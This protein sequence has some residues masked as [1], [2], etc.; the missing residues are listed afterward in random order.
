MSQGKTG[1]AALGLGVFDPFK[2]DKISIDQKEGPVVLKIDLKDAN[3]RGLSG[4]SL[5]QK[6]SFFVLFIKLYLF[7]SDFKFSKVDGF[8]RNFDKL[9][10]ELKTNYPVANIQGIYNTHTF[11][12]TYMDTYMHTYIQLGISI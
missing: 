6:K 7:L 2:V 1:I 4:K 11:I 3:L 5:M 10:L 12:H 8:K 9:K